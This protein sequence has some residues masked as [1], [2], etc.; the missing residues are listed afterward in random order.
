MILA[1]YAEMRHHFAHV[2]HTTS[3]SLTYVHAVPATITRGAGSFVTDGFTA[4]MSVDVAGTASNDGRYTVDTVAALT[5]TLATGDQLVN[6]TIVSSLTGAEYDVDGAEAWP[7][8]ELHVTSPAFD[9]TWAKV[10]LI[11]Q[12]VT[13]F[14]LVVTI[15]ASATDVDAGSSYTWYVRQ[16]TDDPD[17]QWFSVVH[18]DLTRTGRITLSLTAK[19]VTDLGL[20][21]ASDK[22]SGDQQIRVLRGTTL[23][24][25][26][27]SDGAI[28]FIDLARLSALAS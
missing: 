19:C 14:P 24:V 22:L 8:D 28:Q 6:E 26:R 15:N 21:L 17:L 4:G 25:K 13:K 12:P 10:T 9:D 20:S 3:V 23:F 16:P 1:T 11:F 2:A 27:D 18:S 7:L 5:L